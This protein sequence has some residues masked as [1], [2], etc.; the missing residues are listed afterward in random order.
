MSDRPS[1]ESPLTMR[2][3]RQNYADGRNIMDI[4][5]ASEGRD[6]NSSRA[7]R[8]SYDL[9][10]GSYIRMNNAPGAKEHLAVRVQAVV[11]CLR[12]LAFDSIVE[13]GCGEATT[14]VEVVRAL[15]KPPRTVRAFDLSWSRAS[16][17]VAHAA[18]SGLVAD[19]FMADMEHI[20]LPDNACD[21]VFTSHAI[22]PNRG[23]ESP[24]L[25]E[26]HRVAAR[27]VALFEPCYELASPEQRA[28][29]DRHRYCRDLP[30]HA[31][32]L[33]FAVMRHEVLEPLRDRGMTTLLLLEKEPLP[34]PAAR[35]ACPHCR[36]VLVS[37][38]GHWFCPEC[39]LVFPVLAGVPCLDPTSGILASH[40]LD[41]P[42]G[43]I[44]FAR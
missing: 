39:C 13:A 14:L 42:V 23:R 3:L 28:R 33:G 29:M 15:P 36:T 31:R 30:G 24:I 16:Q 34:R 4:L 5:R 9:Q 27:Y 8:L 43:Q 7:V 21:L 37:H 25:A 17:A 22:E 10:A 20:P 1:P 6:D 41:A 38:L 32:A 44:P 40:Y 35:Y 12:D 18:R 2:E 19:V 26:L 11:G